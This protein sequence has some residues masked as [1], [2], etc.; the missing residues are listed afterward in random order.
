MRIALLISLLFALSVACAGEPAPA[1]HPL[2]WDAMEKT[3]APKDGEGAIEFEFAV[4]NRS[5]E[6]VTI[7]ELLP[8][9]G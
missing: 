9:C 2:E 5:T 6:K 7:A 1:P 8:S 3:A 4:K